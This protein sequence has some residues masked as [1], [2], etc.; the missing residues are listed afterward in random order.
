MSVISPLLCTLMLHLSTPSTG[1]R[2]E[3]ERGASAVEYGLLIAGIAAVI[4]TAVFLFGQGIFVEP[5][6][7]HLQLHRPEHDQWVLGAQ[8]QPV[9]QPPGDRDPLTRCRVAAEPELGPCGTAE[10]RQ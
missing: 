1:L 2:K 9:R 7:E 3:E 8:L 6:H 10:V 4:V 5:V